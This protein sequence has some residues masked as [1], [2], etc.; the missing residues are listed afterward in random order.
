VSGWIVVPGAVS[1]RRSRWTPLKLSAPDPRQMSPFGT[2][3]PARAVGWMWKAPAA[4]VRLVV[5]RRIAAAIDHAHEA[6]G[7]Q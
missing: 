2:R 7:V 1:K 6:S 3:Q 4:V 5:P